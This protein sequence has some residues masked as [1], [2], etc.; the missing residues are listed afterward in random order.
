MNNRRDHLL[1]SILALLF[2]FMLLGL[3]PGCAPKLPAPGDVLDL[4]VLPQHVGHFLP[5]NLAGKALIPPAQQQLL[6]DDFR[7][8]YFAPWDPSF[9]DQADDSDPFWGLRRWENRPAYGE[10]LLPLP[11]QWLRDMHRQS[12]TDLYPSLNQP[13]VTVV[14]ASLRVLPTHK[15]VFSDPAAPG[16][17]FP[18]DYMQN[19]LL[20]PGTPVRVVHA[21]LDGSWLLARTSH[22]SGWVRPWEVA[23]VDQ[24]FMETY[25]SSALFGFVRDNIPASTGRARFVLHG[26]VGLLL[27]R[28][29]ISPP[30]GMAALLAPVRQADGW[31][32]LETV[33]VPDTSLAAWPLSPTTDN[34][35]RVLDSLLGQSY[36]WGGLYENRDCSALIQDVFALFGIAMPRNSRAQAQAGRVVDL[37]SLAPEAKEKLIRA[38]AAPLLSIVNMPGHVMLYLGPDPVSGRPVVLH[39][40]WG[41]RVRDPKHGRATPAPGRWVLGRTVITTLT[42]GAELPGL[43]TPQGLLVERITSITLVHER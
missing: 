39:S 26:R 11:D 9:A 32:T 42:P 15:P 27:P 2:A 29:S 19:S 38:R 17:G 37:E 4:R 14:P 7:A 21:S 30:A 16:E 13:A 25:R 24:A 31:A 23:W 20:S 10:N 28:S 41:V 43:I 18:F 35:I 3:S 5:E 6:A 36:G 33:L 22:V 34:F 40:M 12:A 8:R 1:L